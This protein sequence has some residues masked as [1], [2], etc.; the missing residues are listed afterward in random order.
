MDPSTLLPKSILT[1][2]PYTATQAL[3]QESLKSFL[4]RPNQS[5]PPPTLQTAL[6]L[7]TPGYAPKYQTNCFIP[8][9]SPSHSSHENAA[10]KDVTYVINC[11]PWLVREAYER[12]GR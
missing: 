1:S 10:G 4:S 12:T 9:F 7:N 5:S 8:T 2:A 11:C 6:P 3:L